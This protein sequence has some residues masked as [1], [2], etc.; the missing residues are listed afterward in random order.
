VISLLMLLN[1]F[2]EIFPTILG[3]PYPGSFLSR[4]IGLVAGWIW[5]VFAMLLLIGSLGAHDPRR[6]FHGIFLIGAAGCAV[7]ALY[8]LGEAI[9]RNSSYYGS[10]LIVPW[11]VRITCQYGLAALFPTFLFWLMSRPEARRCFNQ[12]VTPQAVTSPRA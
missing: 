5:L 10:H 11:L 2:P 7:A 1:V 9:V 8:A 12:R 3:F 4:Q 6:G